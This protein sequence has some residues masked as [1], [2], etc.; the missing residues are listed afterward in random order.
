[1]NHW[2]D[3][4]HLK[5]YWLWSVM[6]VGVGLLVSL[7]PWSEVPSAIAA[8]QK[9]LH[10]RLT[11]HISQ[12]EA[13]PWRYGTSLILVSFLYGVFHAIGPGHGKAV[14]VGYLGTQKNEQIVH[15]I[16]ISFIAS[17]L[18]AIVA[19]MLVTGLFQLLNLSLASVKQYGAKIEMAS[20]L[21]VI[22]LGV[23]ICVRAWLHFYKRRMPNHQH[24]HTH[25]DHGHAC[26][27]QHSYVPDARQ[28]IRQRGLVILSMGLRPC[29]GALI[30]LMYA[31]VVKVEIF[32]IAATL[33][34]GVGTGMTVAMLA[35]LTIIFRDRLLKWIERND[36]MKSGVQLFL[37]PGLMLFGGVLLI[38]LGS[39]LLWVTHAAAPIGH[40]LL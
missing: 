36:R 37:V 20:Y 12:V 19:I 22:L 28:D 2:V 39:S 14:I 4:M 25:A 34:M 40:P 10:L 31:Y 24:T 26:G 27:C 8:L 13:S 6:L 21:L 35:Y 17:M 32:G 30:V 7:I 29:T 38:T 23:V 5:K 1:M 3:G 16:K 11:T 18:Q 33:A 15:G 9:Q